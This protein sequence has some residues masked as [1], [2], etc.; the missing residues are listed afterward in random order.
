MWPKSQL[1]FEIS[2]I[3]RLMLVEVKI[4]THVSNDIGF[5]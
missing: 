2:I 5:Y 3:H 1:T 4:G